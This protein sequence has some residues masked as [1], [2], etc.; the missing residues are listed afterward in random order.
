MLIYWEP[1]AQLQTAKPDAQF[2]SL[3]ER[4]GKEK[5]WKAMNHGRILCFYDVELK[6]NIKYKKLEMIANL[7]RPVYLKK[8]PKQL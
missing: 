4:E 5:D 8:T 1:R 7:Q 6:A 3:F 2:F